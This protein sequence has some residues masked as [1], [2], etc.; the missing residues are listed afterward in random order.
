MKESYVCITDVFHSTSTSI[1]K[2]PPNGLLAAGIGI[3]T[4]K[5]LY[6]CIRD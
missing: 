2:T 3:E 6:F 1:G 5:V 4:V